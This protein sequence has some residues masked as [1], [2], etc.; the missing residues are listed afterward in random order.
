VAAGFRSLHAFWVGG[1]G[2]GITPAAGGP[3]S[4]L[5][6]W[7]GGVGVPPAAPQT[8]G[9]RSLLAWWTG[10]AGSTGKPPAP[11]PAPQPVGFGRRIPLPQAL[12][13]ELAL[14][15]IDED[16]VLLLLA[17]QIASGQIH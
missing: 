14:R 2:A 6:P 1:A 11:A 5:A 15:R 7:V 4:L 17:A 10:G 16:D 9:F 12:I 13:G 3:R 8:G